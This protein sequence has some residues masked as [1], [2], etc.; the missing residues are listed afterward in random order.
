LFQIPIAS[1]KQKSAHFGRVRG[2][3]VTALDG[4]QGDE[5]NQMGKKEL[6]DRVIFL[7]PAALPPIKTLSEKKQ[8]K[9]QIVLAIARKKFR[10]PWAT[11]WEKKSN[12][13]MQQW[14]W[15]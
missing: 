6:L 10:Q 3:L 7:F 14:L 9:L 4:G 15:K 13:L 1:A 2:H 11:I 12:I 5:A 8:E